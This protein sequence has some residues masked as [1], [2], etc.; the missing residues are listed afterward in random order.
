MK[1]FVIPGDPTP[2]ARPRLS[3]RK[4]YDSQKNVKLVAS[5]TLQQQQG[6]DPLLAGPLHLDITFFMKTPE[7]ISAKRRSLL[8]GTQ[9][10][11]KP[12]LSNLIKFYE[13]ICSNVVFHDDCVIAVITAKK[14]YD[15]KPRT[16]FSLRV[17]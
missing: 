10:I 8:Y 16:E 15:E 1:I 5:L 9:H 3:A 12:D 14:V 6:D 4:I 7:S 13:D 2:L 11:F 17:I